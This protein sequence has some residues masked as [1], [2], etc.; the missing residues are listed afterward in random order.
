MGTTL[1][2][3]NTELPDYLTELIFDPV[4]FKEK[5]VEK[6]LTVEQV[7]E[8]V[9]KAIEI[10]K[11]KANFLKLGEKFK[12]VVIIGDIHG[13]LTSLTRITKNFLRGEVESMI[14]LGDYVDRGEDSL[15]NYM[16]ILALMIAWP[17]NVVVLRG[18]HED[19]DINKHYGF[20]NE[21][22]NFYPS[23]KE[24]SRVLELLDKS[25]NY[26]SLA[27]MTPQD[28]VTLHGGIPR[29]LIHLEDLNSI[30]KPHFD[31][32][33]NHDRKLREL[34]HE[35]L[36]QLR[37]NDPNENQ[38]CKFRGSSRGT[39]IFTFNEKVVDEFLSNNNA[40][41]IIRAHES[42]RGGFQSLFGGKILHVFST[43]PYGDHVYHANVIRE[44]KGG[45]TYLCDVDVKIIKEI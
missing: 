41:R 32:A 12:D 15:L 20:S 14:F 40:T 5:R 30:P 13:N 4:K 42:T 3:T 36:F 7:E 22:F 33:L 43:E 37:W 38:D 21:V 39:G 29:D 23:G 44:A 19:L 10:L 24:N 16:R 35:L 18:N 6:P 1:R 26:L 27:A 11:F 9:N 45:K 8:I 25:Y 34:Q 2:E 31:L 17:D 28:S